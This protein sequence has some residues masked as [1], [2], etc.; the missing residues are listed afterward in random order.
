MVET[1][2]TL[3][4]TTTQQSSAVLWVAISSMVWVLEALLDR[5]VGTDKNSWLILL[6][7]FTSTLLVGVGV[8]EKVC[9]SVVGDLGGG[10]GLDLRILL[11][12]CRFGVVSV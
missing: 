10:E 6:L 5:G 7:L 3:F 1:S 11:P 2:Y 12:L 9:V 4:L 8:L